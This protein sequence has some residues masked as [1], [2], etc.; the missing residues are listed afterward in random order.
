MS[1]EENPFASP[2]EID[3]DA[4][5]A[6]SEEEQ[7]RRQYIQHETSVRSIGILYYL[8]GALLAVGAVGTGIVIISTA[9]NARPGFLVNFGVI[10][11][12]GLAAVNFA[13]GRGLRL[14]AR[15]VRIPVGILSTIGLLWF[16]VG[17][18]INAYILYLV[19]CR[20]GRFVF[21]LE[22]REVIRQTP[23]VRY[24]TSIIVWIL[25]AVLLAVLI[26]ALA[27]FL[28]LMG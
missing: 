5:E 21:S 11:Y 27:S 2:P 10:F 6:A 16:P 26:A 28:L 17:T 18:V 25:L 15:W 13:V 12:G 14:L 9:Q 7:I 20:K 3:D 19:F 24:K 8:G 4:M 22:Y 1:T 23:H